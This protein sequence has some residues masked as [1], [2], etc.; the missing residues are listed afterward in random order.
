MLAIERRNAILEKLQAERT[1][2]DAERAHYEE[3][4]TLFKKEK[5]EFDNLF[6]RTLLLQFLISLN[7]EMSEESIHFVN[8]SRCNRKI[9]EIIQYI[10]NHLTG[11]I[12]IDSLSE[13]FYIS[14]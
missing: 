6:Q 9:V 8:T 5:Q 3:Q 12:N 11:E 4:A 13:S 14:K 1:D 10:N 2:L 7:R